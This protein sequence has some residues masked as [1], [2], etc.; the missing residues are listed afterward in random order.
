MDIVAIN[1]AIE[2]LENDD[3]TP[4][5][6]SELAAL[7]IC[8]DNL[9]NRKESTVD[10]VQSEL[11]DILPYYLKYRTTKRKYQ[12][13]QATDGEVLQGIKDVCR[14]LKE[15]ID[16]LYSSTDMHRERLTIKRTI[17]DIYEKYK[18]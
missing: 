5:N 14:E 9:E 12:L 13:N 7:Y 4:E 10:T 18:D 11:E 17:R 2:D 15:F 6:V 3:T 16:T 1:Q 8:R